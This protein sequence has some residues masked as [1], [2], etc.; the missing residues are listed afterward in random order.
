M[1]I[2]IRDI[3]ILSTLDISQVS[4]R[5]YTTYNIVI[6]FPQHYKLMKTASVNLTTTKLIQNT[7]FCQSHYNVDTTLQTNCTLSPSMYN[8]VTDVRTKRYTLSQYCKL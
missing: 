6:T 8:V 5:C 4:Q 7:F 3:Q 2:S 1:V